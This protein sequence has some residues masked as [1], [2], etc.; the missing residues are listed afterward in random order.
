[1]TD[2]YDTNSSIEGQFQPGSDGS[3]L[4]NK[5]CITHSDEMN[6]V[7]LDLLIQLTDAVLDDVT[8]EQIITSTDLCEWHHHWLGHVY[9]W[10]GQYRLVNIGKAEFHFAAAHLIP[11]LMQALDDKFLSV[12]MPCKGMDD[13]QLVD[14]LAKV[15]IEFILIHPFREGNGRFSRLLANIMA[16]QAGQPLLDFSAMDDNKQRYFAAIQAGLDDYGP[17]K[18]IFRQVLHETQQNADG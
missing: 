13:E 5:L 7:E 12:T 2:R 3:V 18:T 6:D 9:E 4:L 16:L 1:M 11:K 10:A 14:A 17:M 15:H 8:D